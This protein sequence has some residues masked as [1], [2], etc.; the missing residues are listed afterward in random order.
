MSDEERLIRNRKRVL[1]V[2]A[3]GFV[4]LVILS[5]FMAHFANINQ[6][7]FVKGLDDCLTELR[8]SDKEIVLKRL[9]TR[10]KDQNDTNGKGSENSY[11][12]V[13]RDG[14]CRTEEAV[15][16]GQSY[17][18]AN[19]IMDIESL[20][21]SFRIRYDYIPKNKEVNKKSY[22]DLGTVNV[23]CLD[24]K[25]MIYPDFGC[26]KSPLSLEE[27]DPIKL[28]AGN[29]FDGCSI[30][31]TSSGTSKSGYAIVLRYKPA[32]KVYLEGTYG[33]FKTKCYNEAM[34]Y[35]KDAK[36]NLDDYYFY[37]KE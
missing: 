15:D 5:V 4:V 9:F 37:E 27:P 1:L 23:Y 6:K 22:A 26:S 18:A 28:V 17:V 10:V 32:E 24:E 12:A 11:D 14:S 20:K 30:T 21:Y 36:I 34:K 13:V 3:I 8:P 25:D 7:V 35:L 29:V 33:A 19:F 2:S 31:Y 16:D